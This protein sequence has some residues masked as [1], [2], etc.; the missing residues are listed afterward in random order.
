MNAG[1]KTLQTN[2][3]NEGGVAT[4]MITPQDILGE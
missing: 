2:S 3:F 4:T 1:E